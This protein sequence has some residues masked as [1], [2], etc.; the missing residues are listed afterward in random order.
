MSELSYDGDSEISKLHQTILERPRL[1]EVR[2]ALTF[3]CRR[4][5][6]QFEAT[7]RLTIQRGA[8][9][10]ERDPIEGVRTTG[11]EGRHAAAR[12]HFTFYLLTGDAE[13]RSTEAEMRIRAVVVARGPSSRHW[14]RGRPSESRYPLGS[15]LEFDP[16]GVA[17]VAGPVS[18]C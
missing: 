7:V 15:N 17:T 14:D 12:S 8:A 18:N 10:W 1:D 5:E 11:E 13:E 2:F 9:G 4:R 3:A 16:P 6:S